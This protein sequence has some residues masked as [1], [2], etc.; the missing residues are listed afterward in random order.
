LPGSSHGYETMRQALFPMGQGQRVEEFVGIPGVRFVDRRLLGGLDK[1]N[2]LLGLMQHGTVRGSVAVLDAINNATR[3]S[4]LYLKPAYL[5][6]NLVGN[7][8]MNIVQQGFA[9]P[10]N[11]RNAARLNAEA[12]P[13]VVAGVDALMG[14]GISG[15][16]S[17][18]LGP[19][20]QATHFGARQWSRIVDLLPRRAAFLH[21]AYREG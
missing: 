4:V 16:L 5:A 21:E 3:L 20:S 17:S 12:G 9:A 1:P 19:L 14:E 15:A 13:D 8:G 10:R 7:V 6:P 18:Q 2:P 11:L